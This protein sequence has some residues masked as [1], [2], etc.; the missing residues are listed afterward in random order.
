[1]RGRVLAIIQARMGSTRLPG[2]VMKPLL[3]RPILEHVVRRVARSERVDEVIVATSRLEADQP[4]AELARLLGVDSFRGSEEDVL[5][6][7]VG[8]AR[9]AKLNGQDHVV[10]IT[11]D[12][13]FADPAVIDQVIREHLETG[14]DYT[15]NTLERTF[16]HGADVEVFTA[17]VL[18]TTDLEAVADYEREHVTPF[19]WSQPERF[20]LHAVEAPARLRRPELRLTVDTEADYMLARAIYEMLGTD[21][22]GLE[23]VVDLV[24]RAPWLP[25]INR[26]VRQKLVR[27]GT[28]S[29][30]IR[31]KE[32]LE[33]AGWALDQE[34]PFAAKLLLQETQ[35]AL[36]IEKTEDLSGLGLD[37]LREHFHKLTNPRRE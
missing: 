18:Y 33:A 31:I 4:V 19:I 10:R 7:Y 9:W 24:E 20:R 3:G 25:F 2:K 8:A 22:F 11:A 32:Y 29:S 28:D 13:P 36:E 37:A 16:P 35:A 23:E 5:E 21:E 27:K 12:C 1:M 30:D 26:T 34:L 14:A 17:E 15:S 6:R